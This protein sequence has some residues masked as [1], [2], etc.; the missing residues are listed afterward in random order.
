MELGNETITKHTKKAKRI[1]IKKHNRARSPIKEKYSNF[2]QDRNPQKK[3]PYRFKN[4]ELTL[5]EEPVDIDKIKERI[6]EFKKKYDT[7]YLSN[8]F[9]YPDS[10]F[11]TTLA[12]PFLKDKEIPDVLKNFI[13][14][15]EFQQKKTE[16]TVKSVCEDIKNLLFEL[17]TFDINPASMEDD[18]SE[19]L[20]LLR[21]KNT[22]PEFQSIIGFAPQEF[23]EFSVKPKLTITKDRSRNDVLADIKNLIS[24]YKLYLKN[25]ANPNMSSAS[26]M[27]KNKTKE[28][29]FKHLYPNDLTVRSLKDRNNEESDTSL[30]QES[31]KKR[32]MKEVLD[33]LK[34][35]LPDSRTESFDGRFANEQYEEYLGYKEDIH[36]PLSPPP[37]SRQDITAD[38]VLEVVKELIPELKQM[39]N[40]IKS[41]TN[42]DGCEFSKTEISLDK[43]NGASTTTF[44]ELA[45]LQKDIGLEKIEQLKNWLKRRDILMVK[46]NLKEI[47]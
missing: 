39:Q 22:L 45:L 16:K 23:R 9:T 28:D 38:E 26:Q 18:S 24:E 35:F 21:I 25:K 34:H 42:T 46:N 41:L 2:G 5:L 15:S 43:I 44:S 6:D 36:F 3:N 31:T 12:T 19:D 47:I 20:I 33:D 14:S 8:K 10:K 37:P 40:I 29:R 30:L 32:D 17:E 1:K 27:Q 11:K 13:V 4:D 7:K